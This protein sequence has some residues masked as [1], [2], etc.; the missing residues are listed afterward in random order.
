M[1]LVLFL[2]FLVTL[3]FADDVKAALNVTESEL[4]THLLQL[5][6]RKQ[7]EESE[8]K[9]GGERS[10]YAPGNCPWIMDDWHYHHGSLDE[11]KERC[12]DLCT[13]AKGHNPRLQTYGYS[14][15]FCVCFGGN[16]PENKL[17]G[18]PPGSVCCKQPR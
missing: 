12:R 16:L 5:E 18:D 13:E 3:G 10:A 14:S 2:S 8:A 1:R 9:T 17:C 4:A 11:N 6:G 7:S 15:L